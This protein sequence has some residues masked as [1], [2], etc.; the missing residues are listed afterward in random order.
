MA[1]A[2]YVV[3]NLTDVVA[4]R[5]AHAT[6]FRLPAYAFN[7]AGH[8]LVGCASAEASGG[9][10][11]PA[12]HAGG[13]TSAA[14][15]FVNNLDFAPAL[16]ANSVVGGA[17]A[18][19]GGG[20]FENGAITGAFGYLFN[21]QAGALRGWAIGSGI[22]A[23]VSGLLGA[24]TGPADLL[25]IAARRWAGGTVGAVFGDWVTGPD[26][27]LSQAN[28]PQKAQDVADSVD[29]TGNT[30]PGYRGGNPFQNGGRGG[31]DGG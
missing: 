18:V 10:C 21:S 25:I 12:A 19:A 28:V 9:K 11:G 6:G 15:P 7:I 22:G 31:G 17:P 24:E 8:A 30:L 5:N 27:A 16:V 4:D 13:V 26:V 20:K 2:F 29:Q 14:G 3:G 1:G 23:W